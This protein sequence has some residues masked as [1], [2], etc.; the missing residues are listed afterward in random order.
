[1]PSF[2]GDSTPTSLAVDW[3][4]GN[5]YWTE[6]DS[7]GATQFGRVMVSKADGRYRRSLVTVGLEIPTSIVLDPELGRTIWADAG[8]QPK[9]EIAWMDG[10]RRKQ[11]VTDRIG[12]PIALSIDY[13]MNHVL[14]WA[15]SKLNT[16][17]SIRQVKLNSVQGI[18]SP[19]R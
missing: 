3:I 18:G 2:V 8:S 6:I 19:K 11:L 16:I 9:I 4:S 10:D 5:L 1:M 14:F 13:S 7:S 12:Q 17:E 15:D